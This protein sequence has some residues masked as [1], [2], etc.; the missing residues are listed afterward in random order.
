MS[1]KLIYP[2]FKIF[3]LYLRKFNICTIFGRCF[4]DFKA[5]LYQLRDLNYRGA[6]TM[7][8]MPRLAN[9]YASGAMDTQSALM[10]RYAE[11]AI[12]YMKVMEACVFSE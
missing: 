4:T 2:Y 11:Q 8:F 9:P 6:L 7:E 10:D 1:H 12:H 3:P 5:V